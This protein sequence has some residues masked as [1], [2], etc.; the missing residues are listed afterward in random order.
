M[1]GWRGHSRRLLGVNTGGRY[2]SLAAASWSEGDMNYDGR[3]N[4]FDLVAINSGGAFNRGSVSASGSSTFAALAA[5]TAAGGSAPPSQP[6][7]GMRATAF[8]ALAVEEWGIS[9]TGS[10]TRKKKLQPG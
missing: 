4:G 9:A 1:R 3:V 2:G 10:T 8:A 7:S 6:S 5:P